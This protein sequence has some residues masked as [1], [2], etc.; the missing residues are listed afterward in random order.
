LK[1]LIAEK[2]VHPHLAARMGERGVTL[3]E[4]NMTLANGWPADDAKEG[5]YGKVYVFE[6]KREWLGKVFAQKEV[7]IYY[8]LIDGR[9]MVLIA[10]ARY[11]FNFARKEG[12]Y[13]V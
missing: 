4:L 8:K 13:E 10:K 3:E 12:I 1:N 5:T 6:Y 11:G 2:D 7:S 9:V